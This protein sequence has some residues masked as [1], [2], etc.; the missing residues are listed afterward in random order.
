MRLTHELAAIQARVLLP[1]TSE[2]SAA[3]VSLEP[4][5]PLLLE[6]PDGITEV[7]H[8]ELPHGEEPD[9]DVPDTPELQAYPPFEVNVDE[10]T[11]TGMI[12]G[13]D[14]IA[15]ALTRLAASLGEGAVIACDLRTTDEHTPLGLAARFGEPVIAL[16]GDDTFE[17]TS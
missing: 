5:G 8:S 14:A 10:G 4:H 13:L 1:E 17:L 3:M 6:L 15:S 12:G 9:V 11:V 7:P 2:S 16:L